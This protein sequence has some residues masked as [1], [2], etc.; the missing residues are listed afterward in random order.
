MYII[1]NLTDGNYF[2]F[3][4]NEPSLFTD[5]FE[6]VSRFETEAEAM[7]CIENHI[8]SNEGFERFGMI[9]CEVVKELAIN[10]FSFISLSSEFSKLLTTEL[11]TEQLQD[12]VRLN[13]TELYADCCASH[14]FLDANEV[15]SEA[16][17]SLFGRQIDLQN[18]KELTV[19]NEAWDLSKKSN[20]AV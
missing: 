15:M 8:D 14:N 16:F 1:K 19:W 5:N 20:F 17:V 18:P 6:I 10:E 2:S 7:A 9:E 12:V 3:R 11:S 13:N 4:L